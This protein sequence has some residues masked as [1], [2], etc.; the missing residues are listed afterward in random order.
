M[1]EAL[2]RAIE[3]DPE[4]KEITQTGPDFDPFRDDPDFRALVFGEESTH[5]NE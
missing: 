2:K 4:F 5:P 3:R 1:L